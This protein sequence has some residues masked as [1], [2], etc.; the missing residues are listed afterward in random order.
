MIDKGNPACLRIEVASLI[1]SLWVINALG[2]LNQ[3]YGRL[4][5]LRVGNG[6]ELTATSFTEWCE[7]RRN[8]QPIYRHM[9]MRMRLLDNALKWFS[10]RHLTGLTW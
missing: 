2:Q 7:L 4:A 8:P 6:A 3:I 10:P 1:P 5:A 9:T